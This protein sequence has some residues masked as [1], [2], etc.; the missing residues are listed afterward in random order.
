MFVSDSLGRS[1]VTGRAFFFYLF[2]K[3]YPLQSLTRETS[4][5]DDGSLLYF[6]LIIQ[7]IK[8]NSLLKFKRLLVR[9][10]GGILS[11][12]LT[13]ITT[14]GG[15][16]LIELIW[17]RRSNSRI[18]AAKAEQEEASAD[19]E[20]FAVLKETVEFLQKQVYEKETRFADQ[21]N[22]VRKQNED[23]INLMK[24][25]AQLE[26]EL[27]MKRCN[28]QKCPKREPQNGY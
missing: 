2:S 5:S 24:D 10:D 17:N 18:A 7:P 25:K 27:A 1:P 26:L 14:L 19:K 11:N 21:T 6:Y 23:I 15:F 8:F 28:V 9:M 12:I 16:K 22:V 3:G 20:E 13:I 4:I